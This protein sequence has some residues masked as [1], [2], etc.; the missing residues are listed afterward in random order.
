MKVPVSMLSG[1][2]AGV[3]VVISLVVLAALAIITTRKNTSQSK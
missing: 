1:G 3:A 2:S